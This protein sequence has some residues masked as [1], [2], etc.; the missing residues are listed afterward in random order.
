MAWI[1]SW[2]HRAE[3]LVELSHNFKSFTDLSMVQAMLPLTN[4]RAKN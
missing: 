2:P 1:Y 4:N 3:A